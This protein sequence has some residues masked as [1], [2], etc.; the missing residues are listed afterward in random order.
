MVWSL[1]SLN[2]VIRYSFVLVLWCC[3]LTSCSTRTEFCKENIQSYNCPYI[4]RDYIG[5][6]QYAVIDGVR[7]CYIDNAKA[8]KPVLIFLHGLSLSIHN[9]RYNYPY[10]FEN[11]HVIALDFPGFGKSEQ[12]DLPYSIQYFST[13]LLQ[14]MDTL[15]VDKATLI[16]NSLGAHVA[17]Q[18]AIDYPARTDALVLGSSTGI[19]PRLGRLEDIAIDWYIT[20]ERF[21][22]LSEKKIRE[23][24]EWSWH[25]ILPA[26]HE[27]VRH[28]ILYRRKYFGSDV[29][30]MNNR[31][32]VHGLLHVI[33]DSVRDV[34][35][36]VQCPTLIVWGEFDVVTN[37]DDAYFLH[38]HIAGSE[39]A[40]IADAGHLSHIEEPQEYN[41][42]VEDFLQRRV[43]HEME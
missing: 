29:Y 30:Y 39:L 35:N 7:I 13:F 23:H 31:A 19:R 8:D 24:I 20:E 22:Y 3:I 34:L 40:I 14:F 15:D 12:P 21:M 1:H 43:L 27:L 41:R 33:K 9:F 37:I 38:D 32:F 42:I 26:T 6:E 2:R 4:E 36:Q 10:F 28:R 11:Y 25:K 5:V 17:I 16:G 18:F